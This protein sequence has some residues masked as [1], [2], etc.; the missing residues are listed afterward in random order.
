M[1]PKAIVKGKAKAKSS[2]S[3]K[4][5]AKSKAAEPKQKSLT[6]KAVKSLQ[7]EETLDEKLNRFHESQ[8]RSDDGS[9]NEFFSN[10]S[11]EERE[12]LWKKFEYARAASPKVEEAP[13]RNTCRMSRCVMFSVS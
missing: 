10:L 9:F 7:G 13:T 12:R 8:P 6:I 2:I 4:T 5:V 1:A 3:A 11:K